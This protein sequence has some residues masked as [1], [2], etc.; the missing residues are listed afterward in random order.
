MIHPA[1]PRRHKTAPWDEARRNLPSPEGLRIVL[2]PDETFSAMKKNGRNE[3]PQSPVKKNPSPGIHAVARASSPGKAAARP[4]RKKG[5]LHNPVYDIAALV[6]H[7][8]GYD[9]TSMS[10]I[11]KAA[12]LTKAGLYH[13]IASKEQLLYTILDYGMDLTDEIV[14]APVEQIQNP[15]ERLRQMIERH[16]RLILQEMNHEVTVILHEDKSLT[17]AYRR[18]IN[19]RKKAYIHFVEGLVGD[20][21]KA[22]HRKDLDPLVSAFALLGMINWCYQWYRP[23]GRITIPQL[24]KGITSIF[25]NGIA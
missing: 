19:Q 7:Q 2:I 21:L 13:H 4:P 14:V 1:F 9:S 11:A 15:D 10:D 3:K 25:L 5:H 12:G 23:D 16:L 20:V 24:V 6:F 18:K 8:R 17:G 22:H